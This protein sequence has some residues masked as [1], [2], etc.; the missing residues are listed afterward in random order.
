[1]NEH[2]PHQD[3][4][5]ARIGSAKPEPRRR[6]VVR[7]VAWTVFILLVA[8]ALAWI[9]WPHVMQQK[10]QRPAG[11]FAASGPTSVVAAVVQK[12]DMPV[13]VSGLG[14]VA[15]LATV[16]VKTQINGYLTKI[17]FKEG[18]MVKQ[19]DF[20][21]QVD[22]RPYQIALD[23]AQGQ[24][25][26]D[27]ALLRNAQLD[28][29]RYRRLAA[30]D[31]IA[32]QQ[33]DTQESLVRQY[34]GTVAADKA[35]VDNAKLNLVYCHIVSPISGRV[36]MRQV[37]QGNYVQTGDSAGIVVITQLEPISVIFTVPEDN[38]PAIM[39][40][41]RENAALQVTAYDRSNTRRI[42]VGTL[43]T[44]DNQVDTSTGTL[45]LRA[46]FDNKDDTLFPNQ[47]VNATLLIDTLHDVAI[48]PASAIQRGAPGTYVYVIKPDSTVAVR[49]VKL[50]PSDG[51]RVSV[52]SG[53][54]A[55]ERVVVDGA[56][57]LREGAKVT[58]A[59]KAADGRAPAGPTSEERQGRQRQA[60]S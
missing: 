11:R 15:P 26:R 14:T 4:G 5:T 45:K 44:T 37:D 17:A 35:Q 2:V 41:L 25:E 40:R 16:T 18:Q 22:P 55:G 20:L 9:V 53:L 39:K 13:T 8:G 56:D 36:G 24:L 48:V 49:K 38:I 7:P 19:G 59:G 27:Q 51:N 1:M 32:K 54:A 28:L 58:I 57:K 43:L 3:I 47:F 10:T 50:G 31:S 23:Q 46:Q 30:Q 34:E 21:A 52:T 12:G 29:I 6:S 42:A 33:V 60:R